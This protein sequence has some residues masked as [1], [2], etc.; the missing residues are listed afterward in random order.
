MVSKP[1]VDFELKIDFPCPSCKEKLKL[2]LDTT[3]WKHQIKT[4]PAST[5]GEKWRLI[6]HYKRIKGYDKLPRWDQEHK[7]KALKFAGKILKFFKDL[8]DPVGVAVECMNDTAKRAEKDGWN[9]HLGTIL[10]V[11]DDWLLKKQGVKKR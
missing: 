9:W 4:V 6:C 2:I 11:K 7:P 10:K 1:L 5:F 8:E 3:N